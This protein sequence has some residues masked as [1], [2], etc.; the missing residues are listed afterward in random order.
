M[1]YRQHVVGRVSSGRLPESV[2]S[3]PR[4]DNCPT[5]AAFLEDVPGEIPNEEILITGQGDYYRKKLH[6]VG[7]RLLGTT[8]MP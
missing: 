6:P 1:T 7:R 5:S 3:W 2:K 8:H 4:P